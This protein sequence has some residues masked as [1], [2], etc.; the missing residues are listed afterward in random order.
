MVL[1]KTHDLLIENPPTTAP[2]IDVRPNALKYGYKL[3]VHYCAPIG[4]TDVL[5]RHHSKALLPQSTTRHCSET[6]PT[7]FRLCV[8]AHSPE[9]I[10]NCVFAHN[11]IGIAITGK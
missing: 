9:R 4:L 7:D 3:H 5:W 10:I 8:V 2:S 6:M 11:F 1:R